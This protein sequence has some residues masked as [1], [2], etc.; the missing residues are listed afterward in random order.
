MDL[1]EKQKLIENLQK[2]GYT[3]IF[4][5]GILYFSDITFLEA[6]RIVKEVGYRGSYGVRA[7][8]EE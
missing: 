5:D 6:E 4:H 8:K 3:A 7:K 2:Q 1:T